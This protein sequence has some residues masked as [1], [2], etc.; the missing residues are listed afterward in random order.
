MDGNKKLKKPK[1][2]YYLLQTIDDVYENL[3]SHNP[4]K[5]TRVLIVFDDTIADMESNE[6][7][8]ST[9]TELF[10]RGKNLK[11]CLLLYP[12]LILKVV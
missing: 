6:N 2:V 1:S 8:S 12:N 11:L 9:V 10:L 4:T 5:K 7:L 3:E